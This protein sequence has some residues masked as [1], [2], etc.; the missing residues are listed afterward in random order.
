MQRIDLLRVTCFVLLTF[1]RIDAICALD[2]SAA[3]PSSEA[4][5]QEAHLKTEAG[6]WESAARLYYRALKQAEP[7]PRAAIALS[8]LLVEAH[9]Q[10]PE[11]QELEVLNALDQ[12]IRESTQE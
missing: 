9:R 7:D 5:V 4:L 1:Y 12:E 10:D 2:A 11:S 3:L 8:H 6:D